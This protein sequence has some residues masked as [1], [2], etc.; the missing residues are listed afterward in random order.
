LILWKANVWT[1]TT[2]LRPK[3]LASKLT[4]LLGTTYENS[5]LNELGADLLLSMCCFIQHVWRVTG[6]PYTRKLYECWSRTI[7]N[8]VID[9][10]LACCLSSDTPVRSRFL[11]YLHCSGMIHYSLQAFPKV[12]EDHNKRPD[13]QHSAGGYP[14]N[15]SEH[16]CSL[17]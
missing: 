7:K 3:S 10:P 4:K 2:E 9:A 1:L 5:Q 13:F 12:K 16:R 6:G 11:S 15:Y 14:P 8:L 17:R